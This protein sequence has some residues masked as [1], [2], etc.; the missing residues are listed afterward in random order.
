[1]YDTGKHGGI[2]L[3]TPDSFFYLVLDVLYFDTYQAVL[4]EKKFDELPF[5][6]RKNEKQLGKERDGFCR[7]VSEYD[8][9]L[10]KIDGLPT[11]EIGNYLG[12]GVAGVVYQG[13]RLRPLAE[14]PVRRRGVNDQD[15][16]ATSDDDTNVLPAE[17]AMVT[18]GFFCG[19]V[20]FDA[21]QPCGG[22]HD[23]TVAITTTNSSMME[24]QDTALSPESPMSTTVEE[25]RDATHT[26]NH[27]SVTP[28]G[29]FV[30]SAD[31]AI[32]ATMN[33]NDNAPVVLL[34]AQDAP[35]RSQHFSKAAGVPIAHPRSTVSTNEPIKDLVHGLTDEA[36]AVKILNPVAYRLLTAQAL[37]EAVIVKRGEPME[38]E[39]RRGIKPMTEKHVWWLV[40][41]SSRNLRTL[42]RYNDK[43]KAATPSASG[44][45]GGNVQVD[46]GSEKHGLRLSLIAA[47][48]DPRSNSTQLQE[49][50]LTR[51]LEIW[52]HVPFNATDLEFDDFLVAIERVNAGHTP[53]S[54]NWKSLFADPENPPPDREP[55]DGS[56]T[57]ES[58]SEQVTLST[59]RT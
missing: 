59:A 55:T 49:L 1:M 26:P 25:T 43:E 40:N 38:M 33:H 35:S 44:S 10:I 18:S 3:G 13:H 45:A 24:E 51:C 14:Y 19:P 6:P 50:P 31:I 46:R 7:R 21:D 41:P 57:D 22:E 15:P 12:G 58:S 23:T 34:D 47:Y 27:A 30:E 11:Y 52:G 37:K 20:H 32:E 39:V 9:N 42:Q 8:G 56:G 16:I 48:L 29:T 5:V 4:E 36:V 28:R 17:D 54:S 53:S 2:S